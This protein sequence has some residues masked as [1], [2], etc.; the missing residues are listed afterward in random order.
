MP[1][2]VDKTG[3]LDAIKAGI[4]AGRSQAQIADAVGAT[5]SSLSLFVRSQGIKTLGQKLKEGLLERR[6]KAL[7]PTLRHLAE[8][9]RYGAEDIGPK[10]GVDS[11]TARRYMK[12]LGIDFP[13]NGRTVF[14][15]NT[16][17]WDKDVLKWYRQ[18]K[19][20]DEIAKLKGV[21]QATIYR[22]LANGGHITVRDSHA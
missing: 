3:W 17:N 19:G 2:P 15:Y 16:S 5:R 10:V 9:K 14:K 6:A 1:N 7:E 21:S 22:Y 13:T 11:S 20:T 8:V 18:G 4:A 12:I